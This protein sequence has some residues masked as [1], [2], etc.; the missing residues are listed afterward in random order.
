M[1]PSCCEYDWAIESCCSASPHTESTFV[2]VLH[3]VLCVRAPYTEPS[4]LPVAPLLWPYLPSSNNQWKCV[5]DSLTLLRRPCPRSQKMMRGWSAGQSNKT[6]SP[7]CSGEDFLLLVVFLVHPSPKGMG[8]ATFFGQVAASSLIMV[9]FARL[10]VCKALSAW[11][12]PRAVLPDHEE[13]DKSVIECAV[14]Q[15]HR[16]CKNIY[17]EGGWVQNLS[18]V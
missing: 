14:V 3:A 16:E 8:V 13:L 9:C 7:H 4:S 15:A 17:G 2:N 18:R 5:A 6:C 12:F 1:E 11:P 10:Q